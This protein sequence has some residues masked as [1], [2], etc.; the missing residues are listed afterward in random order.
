[1]LDGGF[2]DLQILDSSRYRSLYIAKVYE[3]DPKKQLGKANS[4]NQQEQEI[5]YDH[6]KL[7]KDEQREEE[8]KETEDQQLLFNGSEKDKKEDEDE[9]EE[10]ELIDEIIVDVIGLSSIEANRN[11][12]MKFVTIQNHL[13]NKKR[14]GQGDSTEMITSLGHPVMRLMNKF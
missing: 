6:L 2:G 4:N 7:V 10:S 3:V 9:E 14:E 12:Y 13:A 11:F 8:S 1:M 5:H